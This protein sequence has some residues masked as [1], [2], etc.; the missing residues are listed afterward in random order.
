MMVVA[1]IGVLS[2]IAIPNFMSY[3]ARARR[4]EGFTNLAAIGRIQETFQA[5]AG[6]YFH[7]GAPFP[8][9]AAQVGDLGTRKMQWDS[10]SEAAFGELGWKPE[11]DVFHSYES[12]ACCDNGL[13]FTA[14]AYGDVDNDDAHAALMYVEPQ[15][16]ASGAVVPGTECPTLLFGWGTPTDPGGHKIFSQVATNLSQDD[17]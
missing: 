13:C 6:V 16:N 3:Q 12:N 2:A 7:S 5:T 9:W 15:R 8:D 17:Y 4:T 14:T 10:D 1:L 11:G